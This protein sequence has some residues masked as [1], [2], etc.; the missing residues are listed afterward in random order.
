M[1]V[2]DQ[3]QPQA[4]LAEHYLLVGQ[5]ED[6]ASMYQ[7]LELVCILILLMQ[8]FFFPSVLILLVMLKCEAD[9]FS[10]VAA[11]FFQRN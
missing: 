11:D 3:C 8:S 1:T 10:L 4:S 2:Q 7:V 6:M 9:I 5:T